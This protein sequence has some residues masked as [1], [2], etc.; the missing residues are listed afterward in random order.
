MWKK[1]ADHI[2]ETKGIRFQA[3]KAN[4][5]GGGCIN[6]TYQIKDNNQCYFAKLNNENTIDILAA[7]ADG[8]REI[9]ATKTIQVPSPICLGISNHKAYLVL[10]YIPF[11][12]SKSISQTQLGKHLA[13]LHAIPQKKFGWHRNNRIG[14]NTQ[15]NPPNKDWAEFFRKYRIEF[16]INLAKT[17]GFQFNRTEFLLKKIDDLFIDYKPK[18]AL[19]HG[20]LWNGNFAF[21]ETG[22]PFIFDPANYYG[23]REAEFGLTEMFGGFSSDFWKGYESVLPL[24]PGFSKRKGIYRLYHTLNHLNLFGSSY[25]NSAS[26]LINEIITT[27]IN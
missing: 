13:K 1:I 12:N 18:P 5:I 19:L 3:L 16:Q 14:S 27:R 2:S 23:D 8:L 4:S 11:T 20:D 7:E 10:E 15:L 17:N 22:A 25:A 6:E 9:A 21:D 26:R 24:D